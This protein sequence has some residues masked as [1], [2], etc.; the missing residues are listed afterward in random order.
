MQRLRPATLAD[1]AALPALWQA[2]GVARP[3]NDPARDIAF[4]LRGPHSTV[5]LA[6]Q[7]GQV[8]ASAMVCEDGHRWAAP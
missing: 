7:D 2:A 1:A 4:A 5:L 8:V 3:W 6:G